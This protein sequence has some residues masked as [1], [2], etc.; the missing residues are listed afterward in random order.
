MGVQPIIRG[1]SSKTYSVDSIAVKAPSKI[2]PHPRDST[3]YRDT[4]VTTT[5]A[6][7]TKFNMVCAMSLTKS[8]SNFDFTIGSAIG[9]FDTTTQYEHYLGMAYFPLGNRVLSIS[10]TG[11]L[12]TEN[13]YASTHAVIQSSITVNPSEKLSFTVSYLTNKGGN[14]IESDGYIVSGTPDFT[15]A[16]VSLLANLAVTKNISIYGVYQRQ[17]DLEFHQHWPFSI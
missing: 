10:E 8:V 14:L 1:Y 15:V 17:D 7:Q 3:V 12:H 9:A 2:P 4:S 6:I 16:R 13:H 11:F 5:G